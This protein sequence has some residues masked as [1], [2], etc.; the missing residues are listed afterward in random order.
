VM[1]QD[2]FNASPS[3]RDHEVYF[4]RTRAGGC[5]DCG[6]PEAWTSPCSCAIHGGKSAV[7]GVRP[8]APASRCGTDSSTAES[9]AAAEPVPEDE[10]SPLP[11][12]IISSL[13]SVGSA[14]LLSVLRRASATRCRCRFSPLKPQSPW[15]RYRWWATTI[16]KGIPS[17]PTHLP[18]S[19]ARAPSARQKP[20][21]S[22]SP[23]ALPFAHHLPITYP[24]SSPFLPPAHVII[25][26]AHQV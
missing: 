13:A 20:H 6:D 14:A 1:C 23:I 19:N 17:R 15:E 11:P 5:C 2:C 18:L 9:S 24:I 7:H 12:G 25:P 10:G 16:F 21:P 4:Y 8:T 26:S 3:H 22:Q